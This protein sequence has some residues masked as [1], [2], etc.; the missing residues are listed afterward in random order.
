M[1]L[2][3]FGR[4]IGYIGGELQSQCRL[5]H[6]ACFPIVL[7]EVWGSMRVTKRKIWKIEAV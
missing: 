3:L 6:G 5:V 7:S 2:S 4:E 1:P